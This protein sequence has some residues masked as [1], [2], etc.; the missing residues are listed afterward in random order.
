MSAQTSNQFWGGHGNDPAVTNCIGTQFHESTGV[1]PY[2]GGEL[3]RQSQLSGPDELQELCDDLERI[4][5]RTQ[6]IVNRLDWHEFLRLQDCTQES[7]AY[8]ARAIQSRIG[9]HVRSLQQVHTGQEKGQNS[10]CCLLCKK[11]CKT[12]GSYTRHVTDMHAHR[13]H[14]HCLRRAEG[15]SWEHFRK[16]KVHD[17]TRAKH[18]ELGDVTEAQIT[19]VETELP[20]PSKCMIC[21]APVPSWEDFLACMAEHCELQHGNPTENIDGGSYNSNGATGSGNSF[22]SQPVLGVGSDAMGSYHLQDG[23]ASTVGGSA[24]DNRG[25]FANHQGI[26]HQGGNSVDVSHLGHQFSGLSGSMDV[27]DNVGHSSI[28]PLETMSLAK[29]GAASSDMGQSL[30][31]KKAPSATAFKTPSRRS[32]SS[33]SQWAQN[34]ASVSDGSRM[35]GSRPKN[36]I[37][38]RQKTIARTAFKPCGSGKFPQRLHS[39]LNSALPSHTQHQAFGGMFPN[40]SHPHMSPNKLV[41]QG[42]NPSNPESTFS[43]GNVDAFGHSQPFGNVGQQS[44]T[45]SAVGEAMEGVQATALGTRPS[46]LSTD[47]SWDFL[48]MGMGSVCASGPAH[49]PF[50]Q[51]SLETMSLPA[52]SSSFLLDQPDDCSPGLFDEMSSFPQLAVPTECT[53]SKSASSSILRSASQITYPVGRSFNLGLDGSGLHGL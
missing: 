20:F 49:D 35:N 9:S 33:R 37:P 16:D 42:T 18:K 32:R 26:P 48:P 15:C 31:L 44:D 22:N 39:R 13:Y 8:T 28:M 43:S 46:N 11:T 38:G 29:K 10:Y 53:P 23:C 50:A 36:C 45:R 34:T 47:N 24:F 27:F 30:P 17:H 25:P 21:D 19:S 12:R 5:A 51:S 40:V 6:R 3:L 1:D 2:S 14:Y 4:A 52:D 7:F 41:D